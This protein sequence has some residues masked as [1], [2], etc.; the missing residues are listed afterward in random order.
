MWGLV[1]VSVVLKVNYNRDNLESSLLNLKISITITIIAIIRIRI[2][3]RRKIKL[4][5][6]RWWLI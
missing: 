3:L 6:V 1:L 5:T 2:L 4:K